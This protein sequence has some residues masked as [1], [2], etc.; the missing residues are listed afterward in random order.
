MHLGVLLTLVASVMAEMVGNRWMPF[1][2]HGPD[3]ALKQLCIDYKNWCKQKKASRAP[4]VF[5][6]N[7]IGRGSSSRRKYPELS[8]SV[9]AANMVIIASFSSSRLAAV[10]DDSRRT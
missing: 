2:D 10:C 5:S 8:S 7:L 9:K 6:M 1:V 3:I 4:A